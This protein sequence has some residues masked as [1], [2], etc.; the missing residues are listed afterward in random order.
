MTEL[1]C[2]KRSLSP[3]RPAPHQYNR[4]GWTKTYGKTKAVLAGF[5]PANVESG[6]TKEPKDEK[7]AGKAAPEDTR[8]AY[9]VEEMP[10]E[11]LAMLE[12]AQRP[13]AKK[14]GRKR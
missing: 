3:S 8:R 11:H 4:L 12:Q 9:A 1:P 10:A 2:Q 6:M 13:R 5:C 7:G 14:S